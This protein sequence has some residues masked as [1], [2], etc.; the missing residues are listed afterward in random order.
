ML[1]SCELEL[2]VMPRTSL[3][4]RVLLALALL[5]SLSVRLGSDPASAAPEAATPAAQEP[6][7]ADDVGT[8]VSKMSLQQ[9]SR[10]YNAGDDNWTIVAEARLTSNRIC[11]PVLFNCIVGEVSSPPNASLTD[12]TCLSPL[13]SHLLVFRSH[14]LKEVF[15]AGHQQEFRFTWTTDP[16]VSTGTVQ[17]AVEFGRGFLPVTFQQLATASLTVDLGTPT[18]E[19]SKRCPATVDS[20][21]TLTCQV[22]VSHPLPVGGS[23]PAVTGVTLTEQPDPALQALTSGADLV[24]ASGDGTWDCSGALTCTIG[25]LE[26]GQSTTFDYTANVNTTST[27]GAGTNS[28]TVAWTGPTAGEREASAG[29]VV[30]GNGDTTLDIRKATTQTQVAPGGQVTWTVEVENE[31]PLAAQ[32]V[33]VTDLAPSGVESMNLEYTSGV[34][35]WTCASLSCSAATMPV[36]KATFTASGTVAGTA[37]PDSA[38][39]NEVQVEWDNDILGPDFP[40]SAG[41]AVAVV[42]G[43]TT[44]TTPGGPTT[45][46]GPGSGPDGAPL[47]VVG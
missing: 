6:V 14:C 2:A 4:T 12:L 9:V 18:L 41:S 34:G 32:N 33:L 29:V 8:W 17:L 38:I 20:G 47:S 42:A 1:L 37:A 28:A 43:A 46:S 36:G 15:W 25:S 44:T 22:E 40:I 45:P 7:R 31:G 35:S 11:L 16:G 24:K 10:T 13:W 3:T 19:V 5:A 30:A 39:V 26:A 27:G 21:A 23:G